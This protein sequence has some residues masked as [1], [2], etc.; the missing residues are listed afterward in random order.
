ML[1]KDCIKIYQ[2]FEKNSELFYY[3][4]LII[5]IEKYSHLHRLHRRKFMNLSRVLRKNFIVYNSFSNFDKNQF[6]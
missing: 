5:K 1:C 6:I 4:N 2:L 3:S